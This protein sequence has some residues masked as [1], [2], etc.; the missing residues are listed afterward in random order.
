MKN[1]KKIRD[2]LQYSDD[3]AYILVLKVVDTKNVKVFYRLLFFNQFTSN[4]I[5]YL[6]GE[7]LEGKI[8]GYNV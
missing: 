2:I 7:V 4:F 8:C 5:N 1:T 3:R 6:K